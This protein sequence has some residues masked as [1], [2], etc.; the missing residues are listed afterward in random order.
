M[1]IT[2]RDRTIYVDS[3]SN[4]EYPRMSMGLVV[5]LLYA[6]PFVSQWLAVP[7]FLI[8]LYRVIRY[9]DKVFTVDYCILLPIS[10]LMKL[11]MGTPLAIYLSLIAGIWYFVRGGLRATGYMLVGILALLNYLLTRMQMNINDF[12]LLFGQVFVIFVLISKQNSAS[13]ERAVKGF[14][15]SLLISSAYAYLLRNTSAL[16]SITG[17]NDLPMF[18]TNLHRFCGLAGDPNYYMTFVI[19]AIALI[20]KL[21]DARAINRT[22]FLLQIIGLTLFGVITYSKAFLL[23]YIMTIGIYV[24]WQ[25][26]NRK[27]V[28]GMFFT[29]LALVGLVALLT[30]EN[31]PF[32]VIVNRLA[33]AQNL[34][35]LTTGRTSIFAL[36]WETITSNLMTFF[37]GVGMAAEALYRDPHMVYLEAVYY[38]GFVGTVLLVMVYIGVFRIADK[39]CNGLKKQHLISKYIVLALVLVAYF[40][41]HGIFTQMFHGEMFLAALG[42][43][44]TGNKTERT[45]N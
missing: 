3:N 8:G 9:D 34:K 11:Q 32:A 15:V 25:F 42:L 20:L 22:A 10:A 39:Q 7:A 23:L 36:Y 24:L 31:S 13:A 19:V 21:W 17:M 43:M 40:S 1:K 5:L 4:N 45:E 12:V 27:L 26:W 2:L 29:V 30:A 41:L 44:V 14:C 6:A 35:D 33:S 37:F 18:G 38:L 28:K 16:A